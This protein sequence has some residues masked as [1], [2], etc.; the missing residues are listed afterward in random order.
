MRAPISNKGG[1][2]GTRANFTEA[3]EEALKARIDSLDFETIFDI[4]SMEKSWQNYSVYF[5]NT[6]Y[7]PSSLGVGQRAPHLDRTFTKKHPVK[8]AIVHYLSHS[9]PAAGGT[10]FYQE[11]SSGGS[12]F[13]L[14]DCK[15]LKAKAKSLGYKSGETRYLKQSSCHCRPHGKN[16]DYYSW[17]SASVPEGYMS[18]STSQYELLLHVPYKYNR[19]VVYHPLQ[20]H[21]AYVDDYTL[22]SLTCDPRHGRVTA[23]AFLS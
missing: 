13:L 22:Q 19:A 6:C 16:C 5:G 21:S 14:K 15:A 3:Y 17:Y 20:L 1:Y 4:E 2:P 11:V 7:S 9:F 8:L 10:A 23:N 18:E 12:R